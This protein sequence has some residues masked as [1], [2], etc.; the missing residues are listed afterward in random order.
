MNADWC[1]TTWGELI[2]LKYGKALRDYKDG[3]GEYP[4]FGTNGAVGSTD[5]ALCPI[6]GI[7]IGRKGAYRGVHFSERP[8]YVIDTAYYVNP[9]ADFNIKWAYYHLL[10]QDINNLDSGSAIPSTSRE[11]VYQLPAYVPPRPF[12]DYMV[13][14]LDSFNSK[15]RINHQINQTLEQMAQA[16]FKS[17]FVDFEPVKAKIAALE[18]GGSEEDAQLAAMRVIAGDAQGCANAAGG[19]MP[20]AAKGEAELTRLQAEHPEQ[21]AELRA[22]AELFPSAMQDSELGEIPEGWDVKSAE[23]Q[24]QITIGKTP[25][26]KEPEWFSGSPD[27][28][29][30]LSIRKMGEG[31]VFAT[32]SDEYLTQE[33]VDKFKIKICPEGT[34][35]LSFKLTLGRVVIAKTDMATNEAI[36]HFRI[37]TNSPGSYWTY[38][39]LSQFD[40]ST[41]GSTSSIAT[42]VNSKTIKQMPLIIPDVALLQCF[43]KI[44]TPIFEGICNYQL[45]KASL[46]NL[47]DSLLPKLLS[48]ELSLS[49]A[50]GQLAEEAEPANV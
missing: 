46:A 15:I 16:I 5:K 2:E 47:R 38:L 10:H 12:Q 44:V 32:D 21:Y 43:E 37:S 20:G 1:R 26:R 8:F 41:L 6:P 7:V 30:W 17:W 42:A 29:K 3:S 50:E 23:S 48:G 4:V 39:C 33:A 11:D 40:Y 19:R 14:V 24:F 49:D 45:N 13:R 35:L 28:V 9:K 31:N 27:H 36:A 34:V 25:P 18:A 22:T